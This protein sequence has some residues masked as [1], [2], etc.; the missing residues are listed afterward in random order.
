MNLWISY[1]AL[2]AFADTSAP[3]LPAPSDPASTAPTAASS[4]Q[5]DYANLI[6]A[7]V[8]GVQEHKEVLEQDKK[9][10]PAI[11]KYTS[12]IQEGELLSKKLEE[13]KNQPPESR[14]QATLAKWKQ[15]ETVC[16]KAMPEQADY[17]AKVAAYQGSLEAQGVKSPRS[18]EEQRVERTKH[19]FEMMQAYG[20]QLSP[21]SPLR[22]VIEKLTLASEELHKSALQ[23]FEAKDPLERAKLKSQYE[24]KR[25]HYKQEHKRYAQLHTEELKKKSDAFQ[26]RSSIGRLAKAASE[27]AN[28]QK[29]LQ[30]PAQGAKSEPL[31]SGQ[32]PQKALHGVDASALPSAQSQPAASAGSS[33]HSLS[34]SSTKLTV[35]TSGKSN[36]VSSS[37]G[38]YPAHSKTGSSKASVSSGSTAPMMSATS[39]PGSTHT[40]PVVPPAAPATT[41]ATNPI[42]PGLSASHSQNVKQKRQTNVPMKPASHQTSLQKGATH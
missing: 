17:L 8:K 2:T 27:P 10:S 7:W 16:K 26:R 34:S 1:V 36:G 19:Y 38:F 6:K 22:D 31:T 13:E 35:G 18:K 39:R 21:S 11:A 24:E 14:Y 12:V 40:N 33:F 42:D 25:A 20:K 30:T 23:I 9:N 15:Y 5:D 29:D 37:E 41:Q 32:A 3:T 28:A 4:S